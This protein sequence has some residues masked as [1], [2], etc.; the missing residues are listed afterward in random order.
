VA[1]SVVL[2]LALDLAPADRGGRRRPLTDGYRGSMSFGRRRRG[3]EPIVHD[4]VLV[5]EDAD[6][7]APGARGVARAWVLMPDELPRSLDAGDVF[8]FLEN[9]RIIGRAELLE[10]L[11][12]AAPQP[13]R[14]LRAAKTRALQPAPV[15][16]T[17]RARR[18]FPRR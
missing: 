18:R 10:V 8:A 5:L 14:D 13:L 15:P 1:A 2:R 7:L 6:E 11:E 12:D 17:E 9:D 16:P 4:A 3:I